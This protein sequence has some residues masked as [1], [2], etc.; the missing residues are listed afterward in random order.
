VNDETGKH[1][2]MTNREFTEALKLISLMKEREVAP[3]SEVS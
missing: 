3:R 1:A 2:K